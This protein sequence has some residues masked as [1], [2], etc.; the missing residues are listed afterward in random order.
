M[1]GHIFTYKCSFSL[2]RAF[3]EYFDQWQDETKR[4]AD[5]LTHVRHD[6]LNK[7]LDLQMHL[8]EPRRQRIE[9]DIYNVRIGDY[10]L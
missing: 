10:S 7:E 8:H 4:R 9:L 2:R 3:L 6:E 5:A 1:Y